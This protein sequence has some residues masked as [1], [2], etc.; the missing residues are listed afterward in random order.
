MLKAVWLR[1]WRLAWR[2]PGDVLSGVIFFVL[3][4]TVFPLAVGPDANVLRQMAPG[5]VWVAALMAVLLGQN[6]L[7]EAERAD[8]G[9]E[10]WLLAPQPLALLVGVKVAAQAVLTLLPLLVAAG[11]MGAQYGV[12]PAAIGV[13]L[14]SLLLGVPSISLLA[15]L[16]AALTL[17]VRSPLLLVLVVMPLSIPILIFGSHAGAQALQGLSAAPALNLLG[18]FLCMAILGLPWATA[19]ALRLALE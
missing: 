15:A 1:E 18:A 12:S 11:L 2:R 9:L 13:I 17:G 7:F 5:V 14:L 8:G 3:V 19:A 10:Q 16:G 4:G 6:R